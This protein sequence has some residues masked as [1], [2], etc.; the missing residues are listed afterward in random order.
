LLWVATKGTC[1]PFCFCFKH[2]RLKGNTKFG[3]WSMAPLQVATTK[4]VHFFKI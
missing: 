3:P 4:V 2:S 1:T